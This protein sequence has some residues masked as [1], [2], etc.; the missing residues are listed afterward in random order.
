MK[1]VCVIVIILVVIT[2][3]SGCDNNNKISAVTPTVTPEINTPSAVLPPDTP[4]LPDSTINPGQITGYWADIYIGSD[5]VAHLN[6]FYF[7]GDGTG[8]MF[9]PSEGAFNITSYDVLD[10]KL[11]YAFLNMVGEPVESS[12]RILELSEDQIILE[13]YDSDTVFC[14]ERMLEI[15]STSGLG[16]YKV[17]EIDGTTF[18]IQ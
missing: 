11:T 5:G 4:E 3:V 16:S 9:H 10:S 7:D 13:Y 1:N 2:L 8:L 12:Y 6:G 17:T 18:D 14:Y 15:E